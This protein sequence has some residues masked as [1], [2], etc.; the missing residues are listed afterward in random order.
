MTSI[1]RRQFLRATALAAATAVAGPAL[2]SACGRDASDEA[3]PPNPGSGQPRSGGTLRAAFRGG[4]AAETLNF[5]KGPT[6]SDYV[7][8]KAMHGAL[9]ALDPSRPDGVRYG[10]LEAIEINSDLSEYTLRVRQGVVFTDG[11]PLTARDV[12]YSLRAPVILGALPFLLP[13]SKNFDLDR[14]TV[15]DDRTLVLPTR[16][17]FADGRLLLC[18]SSLAIKEGTSSFTVGMPTCGPFRLTDFQPGQGSQL[19]RHDGYYGRGLAEGPYLDGLELRS[20]ADS[21]AR[22]N[23]LTGGQVDYVD[24][25]D[26]VTARTLEGRFAVTQ[27]EPP[28]ATELSFVLKM[29]QPPFDDVRIRRAF[30]LAINR[31]AMVDTALFGRGVVG[32]D[33]SSLGFSDYAKEIAQRPYDPDQ[34]RALLRDAG[35][36]RL[37]VTLTTGP[38]TVGMVEIATLFVENLKEVGVQGTLQELPPGQLYADFPRYLGLSFAGSFSPPVPALLNYESNKSSA[39]PSTF[40][41]VRPDLDEL[42]GRARGASTPEARRQATVEAQRI[43][44]EDGNRIVPVFRPFVNGQSRAVQGVTY[45]PFV[46]FS[47][48]S[49]R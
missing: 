17:P 15:A 1:D 27:S 25:I 42:V 9:G 19:V 41:F 6:G 45:E 39:S 13:P 47:G 18:Q 35:A 46:N 11:S 16:R 8:A 10:V 20:I 48:V 26:L 28:F 33:L 5:L 43:M 37:A 36:E 24:E 29:N 14:A 32:N 4:G 44:W 7:R 30:K 21:K 49:L 12:L 23:A 38:E 3:A 40:G 2:L 22:V 34:A 31:Q